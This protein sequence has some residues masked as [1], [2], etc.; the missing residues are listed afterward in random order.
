[1]V[2]T[3]GS[4]KLHRYKVER[5]TKILK[6]STATNFSELT[7]LASKFSWKKKELLKHNLA[8]VKLKINERTKIRK[9]S[10]LQQLLNFKTTSLTYLTLKTSIK[11]KEKM[12]SL[13]NFTV[14]KI[15]KLRKSSTKIVIFTAQRL[16]I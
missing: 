7:Y 14:V 16:R 15:R 1:M 6:I 3:T 4:N 9:F 5:L 13:T 8:S 10:R 11:K 2:E 12:D